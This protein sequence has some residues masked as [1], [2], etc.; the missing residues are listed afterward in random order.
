MIYDYIKETNRCPSRKQNT[1]HRDSKQ[2]STKA[3]I[4]NLKYLFY[5]MQFDETCL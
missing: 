2:P 4:C 1:V 5:F 3:N